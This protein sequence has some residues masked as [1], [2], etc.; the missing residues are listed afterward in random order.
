MSQ[1]IC[2]RGF[3]GEPGMAEPYYSCA[4][5]NASRFHCVFCHRQGVLTRTHKTLPIIVFTLATNSA[6]HTENVYHMH[7]KVLYL[8]KQSIEPVANSA[9]VE[10]VALK[11]MGCRLDLYRCHVIFMGFFQ[12][13]YD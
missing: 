9:M 12:I 7:C 11:L 3:T 6:E 1:E 13:L 2:N 5:R 8:Q 4:T 10:V